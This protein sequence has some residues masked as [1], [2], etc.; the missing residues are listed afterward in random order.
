MARKKIKV[1]ADH[2]Y[3]DRFEEVAQGLKEAGMTVQDEITLLGHFR[4]L[5]DAGDIERLKAL[6]GVK[7]VEVTGEEGE[8]EQD[9]YSISGED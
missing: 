5:A 8:E 1:Q 6:P 4:G 7:S 9:E 2:S 3:M